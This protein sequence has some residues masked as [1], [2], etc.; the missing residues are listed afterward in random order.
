LLG[1]NSKKQPTLKGSGLRTIRGQFS[2]ETNSEIEQ[3]LAG[4]AF[5]REF[6]KM[7]DTDAICGAVLL[8]ITK[9]FQ[10]IEWKCVDDD[11]GI[12]Q[13]SLDNVGWVTNL[14]DILTHLIY[15]H[16]VQELTLQEQTGEVTWNQMFFRPQTT[17]SE[18]KHSETGQLK[19]VTQLD[20]TYNKIDIPAVKCLVFYT[21]KTQTTPNGKSLFRNAYRDWYYKTNIEKIESIGIER[22]LTGLP[23]MKAPEDVNLLDEQGKLTPIAEWAWTTVRNIK[24]NSQEGLVLPFGWGFELAGSPGKRQFDLNAVINRYSN[25]IALSMLCQFLVL[26]LTN[27]SGSFSLAKEQSSL[28]HIAVE[29]FANNICHTVNNQ[30][31]GGKALQLYNGLEKQ[32]KLKAVGIER[33]ELGDLASFLGRLL[34]YNIL[35][36]DDKLEEYLRDRAALPKRDNESSRIADVKLAAENGTNKDTKEGESDE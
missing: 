34:K 2:V 29:G 27:S 35:T 30:F 21:S 23:V 7:A 25:N 5:K 36:P 31:I 28:F 1:F 6:K 4:N 22:D 15:G 14:E 20:K 3:R 33:I 32:P 16:S 11:Y 13:K 8:A 9:I 24:Q 10:S 26:G 12:L 18:W 19:Y 17:I